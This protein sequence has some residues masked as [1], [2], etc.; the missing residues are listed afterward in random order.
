GTG[1]DQIVRILL[2]E[3]NETSCSSEHLLGPLISL[4]N[5]FFHISENFVCEIYTWLLKGI[6][7]PDLK[8]YYKAIAIKNSMELT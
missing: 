6:I 2:F 1:S 8:L 3:T 7:I 5:L 4:I